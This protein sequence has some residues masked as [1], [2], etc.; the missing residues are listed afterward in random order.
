M[1]KSDGSIEKQTDETQNLGPM[2]CTYR[3]GPIDNECRRSSGNRQL[4]RALFVNG[5][6]QR[7]ETE[8]EFLG[9]REFMR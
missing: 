7:F 4:S 1:L 5:L 2:F 3:V 9:D 8:I 6:K